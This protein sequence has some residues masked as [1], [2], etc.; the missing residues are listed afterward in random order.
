MEVISTPSKAASILVEKYLRPAAVKAGI[1]TKGQK[2]CFGYHNF[3]HSPASALM[4]NESG[5]ENCSGIPAPGA[6]H[7]HAQLCAQSDR[8]S[9]TRRASLWSSCSE[10]RFTCCRSEFRDYLGWKKAGEIV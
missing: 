8:L 10:T 7:D 4:K 6:R 5:S 1:L 2:I 3:R 9:V